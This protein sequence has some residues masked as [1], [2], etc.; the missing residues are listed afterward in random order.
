MLCPVVGLVVIGP[1]G[2]GRSRSQVGRQPWDTTRPWIVG[3]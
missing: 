3:F 1:A 2:I